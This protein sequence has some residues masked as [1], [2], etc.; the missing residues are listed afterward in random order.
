MGMEQMPKEKVYEAGKD[1]L[2]AAL[3]AAAIAG[4]IGSVAAY[5]MT[6]TPT[7]H[8]KGHTITEQTQ[9]NAGADQLP[10]GAFVNKDA[11]HTVD[12]DGH[13]TS[14]FC[15]PCN[16]P[17]IGLDGEAHIVGMGPGINLN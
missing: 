7:H 8:E 11:M 15:A 9:T 4:A 5:D 12:K 3:G 2:K 16:G 1:E 13:S 10:H 14:G 17:H 6:H